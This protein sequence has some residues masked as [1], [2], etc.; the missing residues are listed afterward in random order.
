MRE[1][2]GPGWPCISVPSNTPPPTQPQPEPQVPGNTG[3]GS[4]GPGIG[5]SPGSGPGAGS[6]GPIVGGTPSGPADAPGGSGSRDGGVSGPGPDQPGRVQA[7]AQVDRGSPDGQSRSDVP[8]PQ[9]PGAGNGVTQVDQPAGHDGVYVEPADMPN[10]GI[11][12][13]AWLLAA[14]AALAISAPRSLLSRGGSTRGEIG[15]SRLVLI[16][17]ETSPTTYRFVMDVPEDGTTTINPDGSATSTTNTGNRS[18]RS[19]NHGPTTRW[20]GHRKPG[21]KSMRT[22]TSSSTS[23]PPTTPSTRSLLILWSASSTRMETNSAV[24]LL[25]RRPVPVRLLRHR[26]RQTPVRWVH[27]SPVPQILSPHGILVPR[28][29]RNRAPTACLKVSWMIRPR[30]NPSRRWTPVLRRTV[31]SC[32]L[33]MPGESWTS[34]RVRRSNPTRT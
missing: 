9:V 6:G 17:D 21:T 7:P 8:A 33:A 30:Q 28:A 22:A 2:Y 10:K 24:L 5:G 34:S 15:P 27:R 29:S 20:G 26:L 1:Q 13:S 25:W 4:G 12:L 19:R 23:N 18:S 16:H 11:P 14:A 31:R 3:S 32:T